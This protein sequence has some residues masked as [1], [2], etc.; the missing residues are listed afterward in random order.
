MLEK[1]TFSSLPSFLLTDGKIPSQGTPTIWKT[2]NQK[3]RKE[4]QNK[5]NKQS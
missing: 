3:K 1:Y 4:K 2:K 5:E